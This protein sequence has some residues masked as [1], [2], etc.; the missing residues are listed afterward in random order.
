MKKILVTG[1]D[2]RFASELKK[3]KNKFKIIFLNKKKLDIT[4]LKSIKINFEKYNPNYVF[5]LA[6][7]SRPMKMHDININKSIELNI[8][9]TCNIVKE[10]SRKNIKLVYFSSN[11]IYPGF[12]GNYKETDPVLP[13]N[14]YGWSKL[15]G[16]SAVQM[17]KNSLILRCALTEYPFTHKK[18]FSDVKNNF[19]YHKD[20]V[21]I[22][23][24]LLSKKGIINVGNKTKSV[25]EFAKQENKNIVKIKAKGIMPKRIDMNLKKLFSIIKK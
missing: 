9:G 12:K 20:F 3:F 15:G 6:G 22:L 4:S 17:Y 24:K 23:F 5:H 14:N 10:C 8:I 11:Y 19:I 13:W 18:A 25:F 1:G 7:L 21:P 2:G 16:E